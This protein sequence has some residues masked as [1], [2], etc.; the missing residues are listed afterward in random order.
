M[1]A[2]CT[3]AHSAC[4]NFDP[5]HSA[6]CREH[7]LF[8]ARLALAA[9]VGPAELG[10]LV[11]DVLAMMCLC[12]VQHSRAAPHNLSTAQQQRLLL[13]RALVQLPRVLLVH[14]LLSGLSPG[15]ALDVLS[16]LDNMAGRGMNIIV[17][18]QQLCQQA[19]G[20]FDT[21]GAGVQECGCW[22]EL[23]R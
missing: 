12:S 16:C 4:E 18:I 22:G 6:A 17:S 7:L 2:P 5:R 9:R 23:C 11:D 14:E 1:H 3:N 13:A 21:V 20:M 10:D 19:F 15:C 8:C